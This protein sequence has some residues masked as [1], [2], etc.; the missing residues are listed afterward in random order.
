MQFKRQGSPNSV[1][2]CS[3]TKMKELK[4]DFECWLEDPFTK[5]WADDMDERPIPDEDVLV[6][7]TTIKFQ[8]EFNY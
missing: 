1:L 4:S 6:A 2:A 7:D 8:R 3:K 5:E